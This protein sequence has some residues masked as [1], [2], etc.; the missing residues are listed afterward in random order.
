MAA[1]M[2]FGFIRGRQRAG[3]E[4]AK[5][6]GVYKGRPVTFDR[7]R[8]VAQGAREI[9]RAIGCERGNVYNA[10]KAAGFN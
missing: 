5:E 4:A 6:K 7:A 8:I 10:L 3:I 9:A 2:E 1:E